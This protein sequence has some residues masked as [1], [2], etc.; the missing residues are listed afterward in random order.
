M[1]TS[2]T[3]IG[4]SRVIIGAGDMLD[5]AWHAW[6]G[7][8]GEGP[9]GRLEIS[10]AADYSFDFGV[11]ERISPSQTALFVAFDERFGNFKRMEIMQAAMDRG[12]HLASVIAAGAN[13]A[14]DA[15][16]GANAFVGAGAVIGSAVVIDYNVV[17]NAGAIVGFGAR[18]KA[19]CWI[20]GGVVLG[21]QVQI[22]AHATLR[23]GV[24]VTHGV[25]VGRHCE[26]GVPGLYRKD[27]V[28]KTVFDPRYDEPIVVHGG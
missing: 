12:F 27:V 10:Q 17:V 20:E 15:K 23:A 25:K 13:V 24:V 21:N 6:S 19:S 7:V 26:I 2:S 11:F 16:I 9:V 3:A 28:S 5:I 1:S 18:L 14:P 4:K 22:G 8:P